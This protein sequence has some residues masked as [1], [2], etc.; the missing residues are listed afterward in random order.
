L[1]ASALCVSLAD[2]TVIIKQ[3]SRHLHRASLYYTVAVPLEGEKATEMV[4]LGNLY[5][6]LADTLR[7]DVVEEN[8]PE[9]PRCGL[10][11]SPKIVLRATEFL[12]VREVFRC[13][14]GETLTCRKREPDSDARSC[15][16]DRRGRHQGARSGI[17]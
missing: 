2:M 13:F 3:Q 5:S 6:D 1:R 16:I 11:M 15:G 10:R 17:D 4:R 14:C 7:S 9:C 8:H 12:P